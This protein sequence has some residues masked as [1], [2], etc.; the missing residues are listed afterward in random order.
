M[1]VQL[2][3]YLVESIRKLA[4]HY[5]NHQKADT[6]KCEKNAAKRKKDETDIVTKM[7]MNVVAKTIHYRLLSNIV[8]DDEDINPTEEDVSLNHH[9]IEQCT[10]S[11]F[12]KITKIPRRRY[13][14]RA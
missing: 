1:H 5:Y 11:A 3:N 4:E 8:G 12:T 13:H 9:H 7:E 2:P 14:S 10:K 6:T